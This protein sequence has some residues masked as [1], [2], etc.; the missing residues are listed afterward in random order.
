[1]NTHERT[2]NECNRS[3]HT[4]TRVIRGH[5]YCSTCYYREF[6]K[7]PC[8]GCGKTAR[9][10][11]SDHMAV[12]L[13]CERRQPCVRCKRQGRP[14]GKMTEYGP[15]CNTCA[16]YFT[17]IP[18][19]EKT[20][21]LGSLAP[22]NANPGVSMQSDV[23]ICCLCRRHRQLL[24]A[25]DGRM[26]CK[27]CVQFGIVT[28]TLCHGPMPAGYGKRC[29]S[30]Y[31]RE[32]FTKRRNQNRALFAQREHE[33]LFVDYAAWLSDTREIKEIAMRL[34]ADAAFFA[35]L[36]ALGDG[37]P[38]PAA[39]LAHFS[40]AQLVRQRL[41][42]QFLA[43]FQNVHL[44]PQ[45]KEAESERR[46]I[47]TLVS[48]LPAESPGAKVLCTFRDVLLKKIEGETLSLRSM[49]YYLRAALGLLQAASKDGLKRPDRTTVKRYLQRRP[50]QRASLYPFVS[51]L[52]I[53]MPVAGQSTNTAARDARNRLR[54][55]ILSRLRHEVATAMP[56][57]QWL[58]MALQYF[59]NLSPTDAQSVVAK[60]TVDVGR[61]WILVTLDMT[62]YSLP[63]V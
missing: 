27:K 34:N 22:T 29:E 18:K 43:D 16:R 54:A 21:R 25:S 4:I 31:W 58:C 52:K 23:G 2:C 11:R 46:R 30:C 20:E 42:L 55:D 19:T 6:K 28:C 8:P 57:Q 53:E 39:I 15:A 14:I 12:C 62:A 50:G 45:A 36:T 24:S 60:G 17:V 48:S 38:P 61:T 35:E 7:R 33:Q 63:V 32:A 59:H 37:L 26:Q 40:P 9:L 13:S 10:L 1:M 5:A 47:A 41:A 49:R 51:F 44:D 56:I 3:V